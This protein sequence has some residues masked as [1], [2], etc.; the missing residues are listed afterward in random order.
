VIT[1]PELQNIA[2]ARI[3]DATALVECGRA[4][5]AIYLCGYAIEVGLKSRIC[6]TLKWE[7]FPSNNAEFKDYHSFRTHNLDVL[8]RLSGLEQQTKVAYLTEWSIVRQW[9]PESRY[10]P[11]GNASIADAG[12]MISAARTLLAHI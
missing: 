1:I 5:G 7:G 11:I 6:Q 3:D 2:Q 9:D 8:L 12:A 4:D 10:D